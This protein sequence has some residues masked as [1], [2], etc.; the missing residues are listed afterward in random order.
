MSSQEEHIFYE[1]QT[2]EEDNS[3]PTSTPTTPP[4]ATPK[5]GL[6]GYRDLKSK[7]RVRVPQTWEKRLQHA[8]D[9]LV[10]RLGEEQCVELVEEFKGA[11]HEEGDGMILSLLAQGH[12]HVLIRAL[13]GVGG[14][15]MNRLQRLHEQHQDL[16]LI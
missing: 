11:T 13:F 7:S 16:S 15:R 3:T 1:E 2:E 10:R 5:V 14:Y 6:G 9:S 12:S 8:S 4:T